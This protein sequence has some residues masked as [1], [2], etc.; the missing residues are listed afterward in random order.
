MMQ[1]A[2]AIIIAGPTAVGK[3]EM[4][5]QLAAHFNTAIISAYSRQCYKEL[6]I[7][8]AK[9]DAEELQSVPHYFINSH[10]IKEEV[11]AGIF[12]QYSLQYAGEILS[13]NKTVIVCGGTGLYVKAFCEGINA[14][15]GIPPSIREKVRKDYE[16]NGL[17]WLQKELQ[18]NDPDFF[19]IAEIKNPQRLMR[20]LE[21]YLTT[22]HSITDFWKK[23]T[24]RPF[25]IIKIGLKL[26]KEILHD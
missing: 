3:S 5:M 22:G 14:I 4:A 24:D 26:S 19:P 17:L 1:P 13:K 7:G 20:A 15:P 23:N 6:T 10:N 11:N 8:T 21:V 16:L 18:K 25:S 9:P 12:E 2:V